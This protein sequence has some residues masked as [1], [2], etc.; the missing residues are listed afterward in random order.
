LF[1]AYFYATVEFIMANISTSV[2]KFSTGVKG[3]K[4]KV[5]LVHTNASVMSK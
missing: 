4:G 3:H 5:S 2:N 1:V